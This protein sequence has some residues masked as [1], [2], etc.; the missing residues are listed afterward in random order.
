MFF[1]FF[2]CVEQ[3]LC[4]HDFSP[5]NVMI[6]SNGDAA[7][8]IDFGMVTRMELVPP[9]NNVVPTRDQA[10]YGKFRCGAPVFTTFFFF[11]RGPLG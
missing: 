1:F 11:P 10:P 8:V 6:S 7:V 5:E 2:L 9:G 3:G 4:H